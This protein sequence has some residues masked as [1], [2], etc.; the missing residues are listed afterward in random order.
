MSERLFVIIL[1]LTII[2]VVFKIFF[3]TIL[4]NFKEACQL[5]AKHDIQFKIKQDSKFNFTSLD[6]QNELINI[7]SDVLK[8]NIISQIKS[9]GC[10]AIMVDDSRYLTLLVHILLNRVLLYYYHFNKHWLVKKLIF[11]KFFNITS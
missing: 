6:I 9:V 10:F 7:C 3:Y 1:L 2:K 11:F 8:T 5:M 4:S